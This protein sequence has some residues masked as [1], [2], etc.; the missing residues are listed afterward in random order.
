MGE[1]IMYFILFLLTPFFWVG[2]VGLGFWIMF[3]NYLKKKVNKNM[4]PILTLIGTLLGILIMIA[5]PLTLTML[6]EFRQPI[7]FM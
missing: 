6:N 2:L 1:F 5:V 4:R 3:I 7:R